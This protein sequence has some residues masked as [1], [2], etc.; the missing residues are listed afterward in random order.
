MG[1]R[2]LKEDYVQ[3]VS[4]SVFVTNFPDH[5]SFRDLWRVCDD[6][7][8]VI[9]VF[10]PNKLSKAGKRYAFVRYIKIENIDRLVANL[11]TIWVG[12][13]RLHAN[14]LRFQRAPQKFG[15]THGRNEASHQ[16]LSHI[17]IFK[18]PLK[19]NLM[20]KKS[21]ASMVQ[22]M[23]GKSDAMVDS[24]PALVM[25]NSCI[26]QRD[27]T[28]G[29]MGKVMIEFKSNMVKDKFCNHVGVRSWFSKMIQ[30]LNSF[31]IDDR[32]AWVDIDGIPL[33]LDP[34]HFQQN[35]S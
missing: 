14:I 17:L 26:L 34:K 9:D 15:N 25:N 27:F 21:Y 33:H 35:S 4:Q 28:L 29:L 23:E 30:A 12:R 6:Y 5:F 7:G 24:K 31:H 10:I 22:N 8:K 20:H 19:S 32:V 2:H 18:G 13:L 16:R 1:T 11:C 3:Q